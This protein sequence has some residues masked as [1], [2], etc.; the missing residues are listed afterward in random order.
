MVGLSENFDEIEKLIND[1]YDY[2]V[3]ALTVGQ[4][5]QPSSKNNVAVSKY[6]ELEEFEKIESI[7]R[8]VGFKHVKSGP[9]VRSSYMADE[10][11]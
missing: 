7:A 10:F 1:L 3:R 11:I 6:Y 5:L 9:L 2:G 8:K 4:Y